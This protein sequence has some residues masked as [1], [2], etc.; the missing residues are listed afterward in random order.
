MKTYQL[1]KLT[2]L[3]ILLVT[4]GIF[5]ASCGPSADERWQEKVNAGNTEFNQSRFPIAESLFVEALAIA[6]AAG[7]SEDDP[8]WE[9]SLTKLAQA[10]A[11]V[12][13]FDE[14]RETYERVVKIQEKKLGPDNLEVGRTWYTMGVLSDWRSKWDLS[15]EYHQR[16]L[17][18]FDQHLKP[19]D[20]EIYHCLQRLAWVKRVTGFYDEAQ[21][22]YLRAIALREKLQRSNDPELTK[23]LIHLAEV[24]AL[25][26]HYERADSLYLR[27]IKI[28]EDGLGADH[29]MVAATIDQYV[30]FLREAG[31]DTEARRQEA[32]AVAIREK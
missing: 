23:D 16:A 17:D 4:G 18:I 10:Q 8:R 22:L 5:I 24:Y 1:P 3:L 12:G 9:V 13:R 19:E 6:E 25:Q 28:R 11:A 26:T 20:R 15:A 7:F 21:P 27:V 2:S 14:G 31:W 32:R 29:L 30:D